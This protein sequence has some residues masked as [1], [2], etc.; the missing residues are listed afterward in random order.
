[1]SDLLDSVIETKN[2]VTTLTSKELHASRERFAGIPENKNSVMWDYSI[3]EDG[4]G[5]RI[6]SF[7]VNDG[8][9]NFKLQQNEGSILAERFPDAEKDDFGRRGNSIKGRFQVHRSSPNHIYGTMHGGQKTFTFSLD[10]NEDDKWT[11]SQKTSPLTEISDL[12]KVVRQKSAAQTY[13][14][15]PSKLIDTLSAPLTAPYSTAV[16]AAALIGAGIMGGKNLIQ[17][18]LAKMRGEP[19]P[20]SGLL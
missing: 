11:L 17:R 15:Y 18:L 1:M 14:P 12:L 16:P 10:K 9:I 20:H 13:D 5:N 6:L 4:D 2:P 8:V 3:E 19:E 7:L